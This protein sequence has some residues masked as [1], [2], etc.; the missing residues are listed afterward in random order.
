MSAG[1]GAT[2]RKRVISGSGDSAVPVSRPY[3]RFTCSVCGEAI[4]AGD[5]FACGIS[6]AGW[7]QAVPQTLYCHRGTCKD[8]AMA[9]A[10][11]AADEAERRRSGHQVTSPRMAGVARA[12]TPSATSVAGDARQGRRGQLALLLEVA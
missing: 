7:P 5:L 11:V 12:S 6:L 9:A 1:V 3:T 10:S 8:A 4:Q 2:D